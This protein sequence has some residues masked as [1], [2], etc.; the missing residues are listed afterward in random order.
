MYLK[1]C[2]VEHSFI[3]KNSSIYILTALPW[4]RDDLVLSGI[5]NNLKSF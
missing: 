4:M 5:K 3:D 2:W 1:V